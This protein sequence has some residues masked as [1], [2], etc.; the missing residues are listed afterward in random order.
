MSYHVPRSK[1][2]RLCGESNGVYFCCQELASCIN[3]HNVCLCQHTC[4][5]NCYLAFCVLIVLDPLLDALRIF[6]EC[7]SIISLLCCLFICY[8]YAICDPSPQQYLQS[9]R[10]FS[11]QISS[12]IGS[13]LTSR[14]LLKGV[15]LQ[16][17]VLSVCFINT[18]VSSYT[19]SVS[20]SCV[21]IKWLTRNK[22]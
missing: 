15:A 4:T 8:V 14:C 19:A 7:F 9:S 1:V 5:A 3:T 20:T 18:H 17:Y 21:N 11:K 13:R 6:H 22:S 12:H 2:S 16:K 10:V